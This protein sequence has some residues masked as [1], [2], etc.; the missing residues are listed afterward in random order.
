MLTQDERFDRIDASIERLFDRFDG[1]TRN[2]ASSI[3]V[4][5]PRTAF[6]RLR[7]DSISRPCS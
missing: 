2:A 5:K 6:G 3:S 1:L 4:R 7:Q